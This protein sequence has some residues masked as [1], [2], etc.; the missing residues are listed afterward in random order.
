MLPHWRHRRRPSASCALPV[1]PAVALLLLLAAALA[2]PA[3]TAH[4]HKKKSLEI[5]HPWTPAMVDANQTNVPVYMTLKN[6][7]G[8]AERLLG[9]TTPLAD[10]VEI[11]DLR[12]QAGIELPMAVPAL[13]VPPRD[14]LVLAAEG[15]RLL[16]SGF[17]KRLVAYD[18]FNVTLVFEKAG[19]VVVEVMVEEPEAAPPHKH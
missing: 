18:S 10:K 1:S 8:A 17:K 16:L 3:A 15:P 6:G 7:A 2:P 14:T 9:A 13:V 12:R 5:V 4:S 19:K 11:I